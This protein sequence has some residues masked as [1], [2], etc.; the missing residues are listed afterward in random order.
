[1][2]ETISYQSDHIKQTQVTHKV[3]LYV[4]LMHLHE[5]RNRVIRI[6]FIIKG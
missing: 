4:C 1:M 3:C 5:S 6:W 2:I